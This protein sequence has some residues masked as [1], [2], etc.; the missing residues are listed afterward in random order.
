MTKTLQQLPRL[1]INHYIEIS[2]LDSYRTVF[3]H[4]LE[5]TGALRAVP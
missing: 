4:A 3:A 2:L 5:P 1:T